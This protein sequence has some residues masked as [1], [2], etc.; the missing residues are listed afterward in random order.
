MSRIFKSLK[1]NNKFTHKDT[2]T[3]LFETDLCK[4][5]LPKINAN[6]KRAFCRT[7]H[8]MRVQQNDVFVEVDNENIIQTL[9]Q[10]WRSLK[11]NGIINS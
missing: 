8:I 2:K 10:L 5:S 3:R 1:R 6:S 11:K 7:F 4:K 9:K